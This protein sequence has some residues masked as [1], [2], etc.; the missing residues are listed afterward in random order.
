M[1]Q[2]STTLND[3]ILQ[4][5]QYFYEGQMEHAPQGAIFRARTNNAA[6]TAYKS[7][8]VLVQCDKAEEEAS[9]WTTDQGETTQK[10]LERKAT[11]PYT[12]K[13]DFF[14]KSHIGSDESGTG[15]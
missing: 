4:K 13:Q 11:K 9:I 5:M 7:G 14:Q 8:K 3:E 2:I 1:G 12:P 10:S 15:D 6:I